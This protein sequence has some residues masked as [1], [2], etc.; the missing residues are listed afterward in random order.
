MKPE[1][2]TFN[3]NHEAADDD[4]ER[5]IIH[6][7]DLSLNA[8]QCAINSVPSCVKRQWKPN[9]IKAAWSVKPGE[10][11]FNPSLKRVMKS[12]KS[13]DEHL[14]ASINH[15]QGQDPSANAKSSLAR[16]RSNEY[17]GKIM[18]NIERAISNGLFVDLP[19]SRVWT[20][21]SCGRELWFGPPLGNVD[22]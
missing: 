18:I 10:S 12:V 1:K 13:R 11:A 20:L 4:L 3:R 7:R 22:S 2:R 14:K 19:R 8:A 6:L 9:T 17:P 15:P 5:S 16:S 21:S